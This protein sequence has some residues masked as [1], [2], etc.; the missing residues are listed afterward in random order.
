FNQRTLL[1]GKTKFRGDY[2]SKYWRLSYRFEKKQ[3]LLALGVYPAI[4]LNEARSRR[5]EARKLVA[6]GI[7]PSAKK[8]AENTAQDKKKNLTHSFGVIALE[9]TK[10][11]TKW[12]EDYR[13]KVWRRIE[14]YLLPELGQQDVSELDTSNLLLPLR[15]VEKL[16]Y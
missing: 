10:T 3:K 16:G 2:S 14:T 5:D 8:K 13:V 6:N 9:W 1:S 4:S 12:S 15:K 11:K 7:D